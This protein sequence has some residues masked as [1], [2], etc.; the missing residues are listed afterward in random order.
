MPS[1]RQ[2]GETVAEWAQRVALENA[3]L[4]GQKLP[5]ESYEDYSKRLANGQAKP[6]PPPSPGPGTSSPVQ[7]AGIGAAPR[8][9]GETV[10]EWAQRVALA[11]AGLG[12]SAQLF[13]KDSVTYGGDAG[14]PQSGGMF[15]P[16]PSSYEQ[17][18]QRF[19]TMAAAAQLRPGV[20]GDFSQADISADQQEK[21]RAQQR[22][23]AEE[24][25]ARMMGTAPASAAEKQFWQNQAA[26]DATLRS[27][28]A[29]AR[30]GPANQAFARRQAGYQ[31]GDNALQSDGHLRELRA[32]EQLD[33]RVA[34]AAQLEAIR[35]A[36]Q[37]NRVVSIG[38]AY[39]DTKREMAK[40]TRNDAVTMG[41]EEMKQTADVATQKA[42]M[43]VDGTS[44]QMHDERVGRAS[45]NYVRQKR[46]DENT[47]RTVAG[48]AG[49][50]LSAAASLFA[51]GSGHA[52]SN[53]TAQVTDKVIKS[54]R[55]TK[56]NI[57]SADADLR[58]FART[59]EPYVFR[60][61]HD[62]EGTQ[63]LGVM[64]QDVERAPGGKSL[65]VDTPDG[66]GIDTAMA[67]NA[68]LAGLASQ[69]RQIDALASGK[70]KVER[71]FDAFDDQR[72]NVIGALAGLAA[73][74]RRR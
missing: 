28:A 9:P 10:A 49:T 12:D 45:R 11:N 36:D 30:G 63:R 3:G 4:G 74:Q 64:A 8:Q 33:A 2:P 16:D 6:P 41:A 27:M 24:L 57:R 5:S 72:L 66:K 38:Q 50:A 7:Q 68:A 23:Q 47:V 39:G 32:Q 42:N 59:I 56:T 14:M 71:R 62:Q 1:P 19:I 69:Q 31:M 35:K 58:E 73:G 46:D 52:V 13:N 44:R 51:P 20:K 26:T 55:R 17:E 34:Y 29:G 70:P 48:V 60:Y 21:A 43:A 15:A 65:V 22:A 40:R 61:K 37:D 54:D 53:A 18:N 67:V 25:K